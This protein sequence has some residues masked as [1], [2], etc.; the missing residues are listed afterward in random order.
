MKVAAQA[1]KGGSSMIIGVKQVSSG[2]S[3]P[4]TALLFL[5]A[6]NLLALNT[7][8]QTIASVKVLT[9]RSSAGDRTTFHLEISGQEF[10]TD[11]DTLSV[12][13]APKTGLISSAD[14]MSASTTFVLVRF[15]ALKGFEPETVILV[16]RGVGASSFDLQPLLITGVELLLLD[17]EKGVGRIAIEGR[18]FGHEENNVRVVI[19]P[20]NLALNVYA[21]HIHEEDE[22]VDESNI[23]P[24]I[25]EIS[26]HLIIVE[27]SFTHSD[28]YSQP[29]RIARVVVRVAR[30]QGQASSSASY[31]TI[32]RRDRSLTYR[33]S[34][35]STEQAKARFGAGIANNFYAVELSVVSNSRR[36]MLVP[37][38][39]IQAEVEWV[40][41]LDETSKPAK[42]YEEGPITV[43]PI[44]LAG[45]TS[46]FS[47]DR[48]ATGKRAR[49]FNF[50]QGLTTVGSA[51][52]TFFGPG[53]AQAVS[54]AGGGF[55]QGVQKVFPDMSEEQLANLT[56]QS[57][58][59][60]E[61]ISPNGGSINKVIFIQR[62]REI[63][64]SYDKKELR[65]E[66]L[67][68][69]I[70]GLEIIG[71]EVI[72]SEARTATPEE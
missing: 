24:S 69:N 67:I 2:R 51:I 59:S 60:V 16:R 33:Y 52:Q 70:L 38:A 44:P 29:F 19:V 21:A 27:F 25:K 39:S 7:D 4:V 5:V 26:D 15:E 11:R 68:T 55:R 61:T 37:L 3:F 56:S 41:G 34:I 12:F 6:M 50:L 8:A 28:F 9:E 23:W 35:L 72:E 46:F 14:V 71:F 57:F 45:V 40:S 48:K 17:R 20:R 66:R 54:I 13:V 36:K 22:D 62:G 64:E 58:E 63:I 10:G 43:S 53:L 65:V 30:A 1:S 31:E 18:G 49:F 32:P 42:F 47:D